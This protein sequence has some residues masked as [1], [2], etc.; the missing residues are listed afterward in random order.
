LILGSYIKAG[1]FL[2]PAFFLMLLKM[3]HRPLNTGIFLM[4]A[5]LNQ[6]KI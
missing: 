6:K 4:A 5:N 2:Q 3:P 1:C